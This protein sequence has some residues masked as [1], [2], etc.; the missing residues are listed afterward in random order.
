MNW[1]WFIIGLVIGEF[2]GIVLMCLLRTASQA[3]E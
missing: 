1:L 2:F 3:D